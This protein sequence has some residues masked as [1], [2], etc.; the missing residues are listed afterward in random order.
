MARLPQPLEIAAE[1]DYPG[2]LSEV[3]TIDAD[4][5]DPDIRPAVNLSIGIGCV[6]FTITHLSAASLR[7]IAAYLTAVA[8]S[9]D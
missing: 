7:A 9:L 6:D 3:V 5:T 4:I 8:E 1:P 2:S